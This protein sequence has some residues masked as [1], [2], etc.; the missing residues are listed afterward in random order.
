MQSGVVRLNKVNKKGINTLIL[1][2][3]LEIV[4]I[5][6]FVVLSYFVF[7]MNNLQS[8]AK[9]AEAYSQDDYD[10]QTSFSRTSSNIDDIMTFSNL[11]DKGELVVRNPNRLAKNVKIVMLIEGNEEVDLEALEIKVN[12]RAVDLSNITFDGETYKVELSN[13]L[14]GAYSNYKDIV[15]F[16]GESSSNID[17]NYTFQVSENL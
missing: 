13:C 17:F 4:M 9:I 5:S 16:Y 12:D 7:S 11:L 15:E 6:I 1:R 14:I 3:A 10:F 8:S 2:T